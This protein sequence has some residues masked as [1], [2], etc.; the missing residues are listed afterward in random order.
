MSLIVLNAAATWR[1]WCDTAVSVQ[2]ED[3]PLLALFL[4]AAPLPDVTI[5]PQFQGSW[6][7]DVSRCGLSG[8]GSTAFTVD[9]HGWHASSE[10]AD[11]VGS[12][13]PRAGAVRFSV[14]QPGA[15]EETP[16]TLAMR[17]VGSTLFM[18]NQ[19]H[20]EEPIHYRL[21]RCPRR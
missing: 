15:D 19:L 8:P 7:V 12:L 20:G 11:V 1:R 9:A 17:L 10:G 14:M 3:T 2:A 16:G 21:H 6:N 4:L 18:V 5:P 13:P